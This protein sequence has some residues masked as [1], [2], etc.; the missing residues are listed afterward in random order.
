MWQ[1]KNTIEGIAWACKTFG[2]PVTGGNVSFYNETEGN[3]IHP[4]PVLGIVGIIDDLSKSPLPGFKNE[5]DV[6]LLI[7]Q[8]KE[9]LGGSEYLKTLFNMEKGRPPQIDLEFEKRIQDFCLKAISEGLILSAQDISEGGI[10][11]ALAESSFVSDR[12]MGF[13][14]DLQDEIRTDALLFG[15]TQSRILLT[16]HPSALDAIQTLAGDQGVPLHVIGK[17]GGKRIHIHQNGKVIVDVPINKAYS[18][19]ENAIPELFG[20]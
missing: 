17:T 12:L 15:E 4:T 5:G 13:S 8:N 14:V 2:I 11:T 10:S 3:S 9:E 1:F 16:S 18:S 6:L 7:G 20:K 19:W